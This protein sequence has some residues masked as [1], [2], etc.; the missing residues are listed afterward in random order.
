[1]KQLLLILFIIHYSPKESSGTP[2]TQSQDIPPSAEEQLENLV[3]NEESIPEDDSYLQQLETVRKNPLDLN[4]AGPDELAE[5]RV[6]NTFQIENLIAYRQLLG[7]IVDLHELQAIPA[8]NIPTIRKIL[9]FVTVTI[10]AGDEW[11]K[12]FSKGEHMLLFRISNSDQIFFRYRYQ[13]KNLLQYGVTADKDAGERF[14]K[15]AQKYGF[16]FYSFH[17]YIKNK[18]MIRGLAIGDFTVNMGQGLMQWQSLAFKK[19][20][21]VT[22]IKRQSPVLRP[23]NSAGEFNFHRGAGITIGRKHIQLTTFIS[24]RKIDA[25][26]DTIGNDLSFTSFQVSGYH[27]TPAEINNKGN[28]RQITTGGSIQWKAERWR[29]G[30]NSIYYHFSANLEKQEQLYDLYAPTGN[31]WYNASADYSF[32]HRNVHVFGELAI[33]KNADPAWL[34]GVLISTDAKFDISILHRMISRRYKA[35]MGNAFT[36]SSMPSNENGL[37]A[38]ITIRP[39]N[40]WRLDGYADIYRFPWLKYRV[41]MPSGGRDLFAQL[42]WKA[43]RKVEL[44]T[45][46][47]NEIRKELLI[48]RKQNWR[49]HLEHKIDQAITLRKRVELVWFKK[50]EEKQE[51]FLAYMDVLYKPLLSSLAVVARV[52][53]H[54]TDGYDAR[55]YAYENDVLYSYSVPVFDKKGYRYVLTLQYD[56]NKKISLWL[57]WARQAGAS[58]SSELKFQVRWIF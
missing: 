30:F 2:F 4:T 58:E 17:L 47:K 33:D 24:F 43:S 36:E 41:H 23:Y 14:F 21:E 38:G 44:Y 10:T 56:H 32:T 20:A 55:V 39:L 8:W 6:L 49:I 16:D 15:G 5:L 27:R 48:S 50:G 3:N 11:S 12:R 52:Q 45:R 40:G 28:L 46:F 18:G 13:Y 35:I 7:P 29:I 9:P 22:A 37:Y 31:H 53:Y 51:G 42:T 26:I 34:M 19:S 57:R 1:M 54:E 25:S